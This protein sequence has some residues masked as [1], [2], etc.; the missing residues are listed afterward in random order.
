MLKKILA[1]IILLIVLLP[2][3]M[4]LSWF[5]QPNTR[6]VAA[7]VDKTVLTDDAAKHAS[8]TWVL[9]NNGYTKTKTK[10]YKVREDY[11]GFFPLQN[12]KFR[13]KG[14]ERFS[15]SQIRQLSLDADMVYFTDT[16]GVYNNEWFSSGKSNQ[17]GM[18]YGG[19]S[20]KD[21]ELL[22][23]M[24]TRKK[25]IIAE[26]NTIGS[27]TDSVNRARFEEIFAMRWTGWTGRFFSSLDTAVNKEIPSW[28]LN[29]YKKTHSNQWPFKRSGIAFVSNK[30]LVCILEDVTHLNNAMPHI[31]SN[32]YGREKLDLPDMIKYPFWFDIIIPDSRV[33]KSAAN[34]EIDMNK[35]GLE[36]LKQYGI[37]SVFPA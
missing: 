21:I 35:Q 37:P 15:N 24:K 26:F 36:E 20:S 19:L 33:N 12:E 28:M 31:K 7:I 30:G 14:L 1:G 32:V 9:N 13:I 5:F 2:L 6:F 8:L 3:S 22:D 16:Y 34:F 4:W 23:M 10:P 27:P 17:Y 29:N 11:Y 25:L 18:I